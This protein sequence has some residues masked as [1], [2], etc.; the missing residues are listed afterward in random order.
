ML[1]V[2][3]LTQA[4]FDVTAAH[5]GQKGFEI[6]TEN[7]FD[8]IA[9]DVALPG[10][11]GFEICSDLKQRHISHTTPIVFVSQHSSMENQQRAFELGAAD[12]IEQ[13]FDPKEFLSRVCSCLK[14]HT[15][16]SA[17]NSAY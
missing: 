11:D 6:A 14:S 12:F 17:V 2:S 9:L 7:K 15:G 1:M 10:I 13:P 16:L 8:L 4:G 3:L 5:T